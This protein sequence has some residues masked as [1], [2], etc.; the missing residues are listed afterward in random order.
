MNTPVLPVE[1]T[2]I[3]ADAP[4]LRGMRQR[5]QQLSIRFAKILAESGGRLLYMDEPGNVVTV[6]LSPEKPLS[7]LWSWISGPCRDPDTGIMHFVPPAGL[8]FGYHSPGINGWNHLWA[9]VSLGT[10]FNPSDGPVVLIVCNVLGAG[11]LGT[12][13]EDAVIYDCADEISEFRQARIKRE[14][15]VAQERR[16][17]GRVDA[18]VTTSQSLHDSKTPYAKRT[19]LIR[20][21]AEIEHFNPAMEP[22][23]KPKDIAHLD[24]PIVGF[25]GYL[26]DWLDWPL[27]ESVVK[28]GA[29]FDWVFIGP[30]VR[31]LSSLEAIPNFHTLGRKPYDELPDYLGHFACAH[32]PFDRTPLTMNVN[33]VKLYEYLA[34][35]VPV[36]ATSLPELEAFRDVCSI[37]DDPVE[38]LELV[39]RAVAEDSP[40]KRV[41]RIARV[42]DETWDSRVQD[43]CRLINELIV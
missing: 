7:N 33:P 39:R 4:P 28:E 34:G 40:E 9:R 5:V 30:T 16:L 20:N 43:Y 21:A 27:I 3:V 22:K 31:N 6:F 42:A 15:V 32:I 2:L 10:R 19:E 29:E 12:F 38:Y 26:A 35:G 24:K 36:V 18:V 8:P 1:T 11:W 13:G 37:T 23:Q 41:M 25:Y 14:A 17:L